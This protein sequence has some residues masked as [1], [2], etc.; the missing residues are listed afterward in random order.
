[1]LVD[2]VS[3]AVKAVGEPRVN[4][5][6]PRRVRVAIVV[7]ADGQVHAVIGEAVGGGDI[8]VKRVT[9][10]V[11]GAPG[12]GH[13]V[14]GKRDQLPERAVTVAVDGGVTVMF[15]DRQRIGLAFE[16]VLAA[17][18][19]VRERNEDLA[20][21]T[22]HQI[23]RAKGDGQIFALIGQFAHSG[24]KF[25]D[26]GFIVAVGDGELLSGT[27]RQVNAGHSHSIVPLDRFR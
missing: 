21:A 13:C 27:G 7:G 26:D 9:D 17:F 22:G 6:S 1:M 20:V 14:F 18:D 3:I 2:L 23:I 10:H 8:Q 19:T 4:G 25:G 12:E 11:G 16:R 5:Q 24:A 15:V